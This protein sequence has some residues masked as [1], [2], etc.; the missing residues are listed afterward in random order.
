MNYPMGKSPKKV[1][2]IKSNRSKYRN[3]KTKYDG[4][5][6]DSIKEKYRYIELK[7]LERKGKIS[8]LR[9]QVK[10]ELQPKYEIGGEKIRAI[11]YIADF[12]YELKGDEI[13]EDTKGYRTQIYKLKK[14]MFEY[15]YNKKII[16][17]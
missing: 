13:V 5:I 6:F 2:V 7:E 4:K 14:K 15:K 11:H 12:V 10:Y 17:R 1:K 16:E 9:T 8:N 3:I